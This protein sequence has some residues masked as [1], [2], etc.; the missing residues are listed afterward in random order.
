VPGS[1][2]EGRVLARYWRPRDT[3]S[4]VTPP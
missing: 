1:L 2:I 4:Q 3:K